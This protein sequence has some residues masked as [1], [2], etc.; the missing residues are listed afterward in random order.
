MTTSS[1][2]SEGEGFLCKASPQQ[3][4]LRLSDP[5][6]GQGAGG[7]ARALDRKIPADLRPDSLVTV[8]P[9]PPQEEKAEVVWTH[10][11]ITRPYLDQPARIS[12]RV[13]RI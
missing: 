5:S 2:E 3:G 4:D 7:K 12:A 10:Q 11:Q 8:P 6:L 1:L 13:R 9:M